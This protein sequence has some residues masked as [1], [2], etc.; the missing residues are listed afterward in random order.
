PDSEFRVGPNQVQWTVGRSLGKVVRVLNPS[1]PSHHLL[2]SLLVFRQ[3]LRGPVVMGGEDA[4][5]TM[6]ERSETRSSPLPR[7]AGLL[8]RYDY[9]RI[10]RNIAIGVGA[11]FASLG[12]FVSLGLL[13]VYDFPYA[14]STL[15]ALKIGATNTL[16]LMGIVIPVGF[17]AGVTC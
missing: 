10:I 14:V 13:G 7:A 6:E 15:N 1:G 9:A 4:S 8:G 2:F 3:S 5:T 12:V 17:S 16:A 11:A